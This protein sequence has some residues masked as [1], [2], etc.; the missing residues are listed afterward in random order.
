MS[1]LHQVTPPGNAGHPNADVV[2]RGRTAHVRRFRRVRRR[3]VGNLHPRPARRRRSPCLVAAWHPRDAC[4]VAR[5][6]PAACRTVHRCRH[7]P[8]RVRRQRDAGQRRTARAVL[9]AIPGGRPGRGDAGTRVRELL[10][11]RPRPRCGRCAYRTA[12]DH[13]SSVDRVA[14]LDIVPTGHAFNHADK[15]FSLGYWMWSFLAAPHPVPE[16]LISRDPEVLVNH[17]L[18]EWSADPEQLLQR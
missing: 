3:R 10:S 9:N 1:S 18:D 15:D 16:T 7:R 2:R 12:L 14:V 5:D 8:T 6:S 17:M 13:Q 11:G 4:H